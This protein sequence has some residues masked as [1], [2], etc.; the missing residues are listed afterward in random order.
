ME[1]VVNQNTQLKSAYTEMQEKYA[2]LKEELRGFVSEKY[3]QQ[4]SKVDET[5]LHAQMEA[6][7][8]LIKMWQGRARDA[9]EKLQRVGVKV[10]SDA[11]NEETLDK[12]DYVSGKH[13]NAGLTKTSLK[14]PMST[15]SKKKNL[16]FTITNTKTNK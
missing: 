5:G 6:A 10:K 8:G 9:E 1:I 3:K 16:T 12:Q 13:P 14:T 2:K 15:K 7:S 4:N 11:D